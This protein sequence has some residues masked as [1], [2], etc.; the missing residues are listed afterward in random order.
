[1]FFLISFSVHNPLPIFPPSLVFF[2]L[3][4]KCSLHMRTLALCVGC[5]LDIL[6]LL[7][8]LF[9]YGFW[10]LWV[11]F[12]CCCEVLGTATI[13]LW[14]PFLRMGEG[15]VLLLHLNPSH[16]VPHSFQA[17]PQVTDLPGSVT[18]NQAILRGERSQP[19]WCRDTCRALVCPESMLGPSSVLFRCAAL[20]LKGESGCPAPLS[21][22]SGGRWDMASSW[23][24]NA[25]ASGGTATEGGP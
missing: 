22:P 5:K 17:Q 15:R 16:C 10:S 14:V 6:F 4:C 8:I 13:F 7:L 9:C 20:R 11:I 21:S 23:P 19:Q 3:I 24:K 1:M 25:R 18:P 12:C 2:L